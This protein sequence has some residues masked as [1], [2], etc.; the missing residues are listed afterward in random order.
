MSRQRCLLVSPFSHC[1]DLFKND[2]KQEHDGICLKFL[3]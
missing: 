2:E 1:P 3:A